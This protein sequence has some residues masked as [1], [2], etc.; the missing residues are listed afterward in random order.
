MEL[1]YPASPD[2]V[3]ADLIEPSFSYK[4]SA[5]LAVVSLAIFG[6]A[7]LGLIGWLLWT[8]CRLFSAAGADTANVFVAIGTTFLGLFLIKALFFLE[9]GEIGDD[10]EVTRRISL[11]YSSF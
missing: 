9:R 5:W 8:S 2:Q 10:L 11:A 4:R 7:Y 1:I 6:V 3:P